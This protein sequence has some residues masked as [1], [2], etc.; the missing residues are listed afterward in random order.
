MARQSAPLQ[1][2][3]LMR[4]QSA[5]IMNHQMAADTKLL[6]SDQ[7]QVTQDKG[8]AVLPLHIDEGVPAGC[9]WVPS[10]VDAV[11]DLSAAY[12][13]IKLEKVS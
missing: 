3:P 13:K 12:G 5:V 8:T 7:V 11:R 1:K 9:V 6:G 2:T 10:G 4:L